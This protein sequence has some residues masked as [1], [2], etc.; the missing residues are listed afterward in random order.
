MKE[1]IRLWIAIGD[2]LCLVTGIVLL[3]DSILLPR[4]IVGAVLIS[5]SWGGAIW[6]GLQEGKEMAKKKEE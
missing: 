3:I 6:I 4:I 1:Y 2:M 5:L